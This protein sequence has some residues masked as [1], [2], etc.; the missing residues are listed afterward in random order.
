MLETKNGRLI[1]L[2]KYGIY[3]IK[4]SRFIK[5]QEAKCLKTPLSKIQILGDVFFKCNSIVFYYRYQINGILNTFLL[6]GNKFMSEMHLKQLGF[7]Y[8][9][10]GPF[11]KNKRRIQK[12]S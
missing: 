2:S 6:G 1:L 11:T 9:A 3:G 7:T 12:C 4:K 10:C 5:E 8:S